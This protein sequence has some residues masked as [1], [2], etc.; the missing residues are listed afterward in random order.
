MSCPEELELFLVREGGGA[1]EGEGD[2]D[3]KLTPE[4]AQEVSAHLATCPEC[5]TKMAELQALGAALAHPDPVPE[6]DRAAFV[7]DVVRRI[8]ERDAQTPLPGFS[9]LWGIGVPLAAAVCCGLVALVVLPMSLMLSVG[10][11]D[12]A[13][14]AS[15]PTVEQ[16]ISRSLLSEPGS[17]A[18]PPAE[19]AGESDEEASSAD[20]ATPS[21]APS[22][23][24]TRAAPEGGGS[25]ALRRTL[26]GALGSQGTA[27]RGGPN[28]VG[29]SALAETPTKARRRPMGATAGRR[30]KA[31][32]SERRRELN[33][34]V[35]Q[36][37]ESQ[38]SLGNASPDMSALPSAQVGVPGRISTSSAPQF[39]PQPVMP[40]AAPASAIDPNG[41]FATTYRPGRGHIARFEKTML[42]GQN[43][44]EP[45]IAL[46]AD[47]GRGH[48]PQV[49]P[50]TGR[51]LDVH[52]T[53]GMS[54][55]PPQGGPVHL[56]ITLRSTTQQPASRPKVAVHLVIDTSGSMSG[57]PIQ[58][59]RQAAQQL[60][61]LLQDGDRFSLTQYSSDARVVIPDGPVGRRRALIT[62]QIMGLHASGGTNLEAGLRQGYEQAR[63]SRTHEDAVQLTIVLSDGRPNQG[64]T[65]PWVLSEM[66]ATAFQAA[67]E[68]TTIGVG[69]NYEPQVMSAIAE[70]GAGGYYYLPDASNIEQVLRTELDVRCQPV[71]RGVELR[72]R[73][74]NGVELLEAYGSR[75]LNEM[76]ASRVRGAEVAIDHQEAHRTGINRD[77]QE[78]REGG[79]RFFIP[80]FARDDQHTVLLQLR[81]P[82]GATGTELSLADVELR[83]KDRVLGINQGDERQVRVSYG[84]TPTEALASQDRSVRRA[85]FSFRTGQSLVQ[86]SSQLN[87]G[88]N[89]E[90][91]RSLFERVEVLRRAGEQLDDGTLRADADRL[92]SFREAVLNQT[93]GNNLMMGS[94]VQRAG[95]AFMR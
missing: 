57:T 10:G 95:N 39:A 30:Q 81:V 50:P 9:K 84:S 25:E 37:S 14:V 93:M 89:D 18:A 22:Q 29:G 68:T 73:L 65:N 33:K 61:N 58:H 67:V 27:R 24:A 54:K 6:T 77:R 38:R 76:E 55:L 83:Y 36:L 66:S 74:G 90:A 78:D 34:I 79:M 7:A 11:E 87:R 45:V 4:R 12:E 44:P 31:A 2:G 60:V 49:N 13:A 20:M 40:T 8:D 82:A 59:A 26:D 32:E 48:G 21:P 70:Y 17:A 80:G 51:A 46:V 53:P 5:Q 35:G 94:L 85:V 16:G 71:A 69:D 47:E 42:Q 72:V 91:L 28:T 63:Q 3:V 43:I 52:L 19:M 41:R 64:N 62:G 1:G 15:S 56:A 75:R 92:N 23:P 88:E 86:V